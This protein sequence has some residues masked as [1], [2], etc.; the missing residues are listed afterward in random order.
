MIPN[1]KLK[2]LNERFHEFKSQLI[3]LFS[4]EIAFFPFEINTIWFLGTTRLLAARFLRQSRSAEGR[5]T[6]AEVAS[7]PLDAK[8]NHPCNYLFYVLQV[9]YGLYLLP[10]HTG[11]ESHMS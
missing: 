7:K 4:R 2:V 5:T 1:L 9:P 11:R 6:S 8:A 10:A 3:G